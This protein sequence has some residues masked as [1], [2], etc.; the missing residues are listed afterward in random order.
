MSLPQP[1]VKGLETGD[2]T[3]GS[4]DMLGCAVA[5]SLGAACGGMVGTMVADK[6][7]HPTLEVGLNDSALSCL[8]EIGARTN[9]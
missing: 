4:K 6:I 9:T 7:T 1:N 5:V 3:H 2:F 8:V